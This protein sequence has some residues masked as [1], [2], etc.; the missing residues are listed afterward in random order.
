MHPETRVTVL[1]NVSAW[2]TSSV[3][4]MSSL[5][6]GMGPSGASQISYFQY[7]GMLKWETSKVTSM[8]RMFQYLEGLTDFDPPSS[9]SQWNTTNV[10]YFGGMFEGCRKVNLTGQL[11]EWETS[12]AVSMSYMYNEANSANP[13][14]GKW[15]L[16]KVTSLKG[17]FTNARAARPDV[18]LWNT[19]L[20]ED[21]S[22]T[23]SEL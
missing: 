16:G 18:R 21:F 9:L 14:V 1:L 13:S 19:G 23:F 5:F 3:E 22:L 8:D 12:S 7:P 20:V 10:R 6:S 11:S 4:D 17:M 2:D 15:N